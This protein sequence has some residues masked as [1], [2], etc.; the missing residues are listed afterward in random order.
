MPAS[1]MCDECGKRGKLNRIRKY[2]RDRKV[3]LRICFVG[4]FVEYEIWCQDSADIVGLSRVVE[5]GG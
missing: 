3:H 1:G 5:N 4:Y 2:I